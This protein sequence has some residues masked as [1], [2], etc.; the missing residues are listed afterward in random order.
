MDLE[1]SSMVV[2]IY[3]CTQ[4]QISV[5]NFQWK[6]KKCNEN[7]APIQERALLLFSYSGAPIGDNWQ[8][9]VPYKAQY[10][11]AVKLA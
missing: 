5:R 6:F 4:F 3:V 9:P 2:R 10:L 8:K 7:P 1:Y 11:G